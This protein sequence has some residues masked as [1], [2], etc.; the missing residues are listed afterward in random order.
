MDINFN[1]SY[2]DISIV[3][4][5]ISMIKTREKDLVQKIIQT[6]RT[7]FKDYE[8][9]ENYGC[10][11]DSYVGLPITPK[12]AEEIKNNIIFSI[13]KENDLLYAVNI[14]VPYIIEKN[15][16]HY[17]IIIDGLDTI[18]YSFVKDKGFKLP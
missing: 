1:T 5:D 9:S 2:G 7:N 14:N 16:I 12:L 3:S 6:L 17:R 10:N 4:N 8:L 13:K 11:L 18:K 15:T